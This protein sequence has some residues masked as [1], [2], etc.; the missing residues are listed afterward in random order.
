MILAAKPGIVVIG[1]AANGRQAVELA[2]RLRP[3]VCLFD[4][5]MPGMDG[6]EATRALAGPTV[7]DW[8]YS[9]DNWQTL[10]AL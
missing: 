10:S 6:V 7:H 4:I 3:D 5:R 9:Y 2:R 8:T 1:E